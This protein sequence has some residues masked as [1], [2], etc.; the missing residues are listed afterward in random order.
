MPERHIMTKQ[1]NIR[2]PQSMREELIAA[3]RAL[4]R[5]QADVVAEALAQWLHEKRRDRIA[6]MLEAAGLKETDGTP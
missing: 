6:R 3:A 2:L 1:F 5:S 4:K